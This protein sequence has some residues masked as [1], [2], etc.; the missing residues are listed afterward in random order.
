M[1]KITVQFP[2]Y[3]F[4]TPRVDKG[5]SASVGWKVRPADLMQ[6]ETILVPAPKYRG[7]GTTEDGEN[8]SKA[9][10]G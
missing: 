10:A 4:S 5:V 9:T 6:E 3:G 1:R 7:S 2:W 8:E